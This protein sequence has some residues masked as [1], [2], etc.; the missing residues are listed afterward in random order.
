M[1]PIKLGVVMDP[2][3]AIHVKK[4]STLAMLQAAQARGWELYYMEQ[5]DLFLRDGDAFA[6]TRR[7]T[8]YKDSDRWFALGAEGL[9]RL[10]ELD[11]VLMRKDP[12][13]NME[14]VYTT[15]LLERAQAAGA[16]VVNDPR[17]LRDANEK[18]FTAWFPQC[19]PPTLVTRQ[20]HRIRAFLDEHGTVVIKPLGAMAGTLVFKLGRDDPNTSVVIEMMTKNDGRFVMAQ[21]FVPE[22]SAGDKRILMIDGEPVP[23][24][25]ARIPAPG[26]TRGN[27]AAGAKGV[28]QPLSERDRWICAQVGPVLREKGIL[29]AGLDIIGD[30]L[31]EINVTSP[32]GIR[33]LDKSFNLNIAGQFL[34]AVAARLARHL[35]SPRT[36]DGA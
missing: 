33:E 9:Y 7:L 28:G 1:A 34:D 19:T 14:Y 6:R 26:E 22:I 18:L 17:S 23:Y 20:G 30:Y 29:F 31:T 36:G 32:T 16:L 12:P 4:D 11:I 8:V 27:L 13:F 25:L 24:A 15:Y 2:I 3:G 5:G 35:H 21:R 10:G